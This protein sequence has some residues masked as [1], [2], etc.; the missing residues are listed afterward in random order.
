MS[1]PIRSRKLEKIWWYRG[2]KCAI[3]L[4]RTILGN[5]RCGYVRVT[6]FHTAFEDDYQ[7]MPKTSIHEGLTDSWYCLP[8]NK[9]SLWNRFINWFEW[10]IRFSWWFGFDCAHAVD[11][12]DPKNIDFCITQCEGLV[13]DLILMQKGEL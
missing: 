11:E 8:K 9:M 1:I 6:R 5:F 13:D 2:Y 12:L 4:S 3:V 10:K 7:I